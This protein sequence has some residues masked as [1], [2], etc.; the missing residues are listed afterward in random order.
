MVPE[1]DS[2]RCVSKDVGPPRGWIVRS[3]IGWIGEQNIPYMGVETS[4]YILI[5][6]LLRKSTERKSQ[7][8]QYLLAVGVGLGYSKNNL[9]G[10]KVQMVAMIQ[11]HQKSD[12]I[13]K[14]N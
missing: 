3:H 11:M 7:R 9:D 10:S 12:V 13:L 14:E 5:L 2:E 4:P 6:K 1:P 8:R